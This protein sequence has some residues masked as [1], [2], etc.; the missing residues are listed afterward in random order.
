GLDKSRALRALC[1]RA[2]WFSE[3][4]PLGVDA[5][6]VIERTAGVWIAEAAEMVGDKDADKMK[7][8]LST[9]VDGP[10]RLAYA[11][12]PVLVPR[13]FVAIGTTNRKDYLR[14]TTGNR[15]FWPVAVRGM[16]VEALLRDRDQLWAE[17]SALEASGISTHLDRALWPAAGKEQ[18]KRMTSDPW[19]D[20]LGEHFGSAE[21]KVLAAT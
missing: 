14:D 11:R 12:E 19:E 10:V 21:G 13:Q 5:K 6:V 8:F 15:R 16:S 1:P 20:V 9:T 4:L 2:E 7:A 3:N 17:A 18:E